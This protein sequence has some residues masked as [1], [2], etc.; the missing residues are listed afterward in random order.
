MGQIHST[1][2]EEKAHKCPEEVMDLKDGS[3][4]QRTD[5]PRGGAGGKLEIGSQHCSLHYALGS[6]GI[7]SSR[8]GTQHPKGS[9]GFR[10]SQD[11]ELQSTGKGSAQMGSRQAQ[12]Q[13]LQC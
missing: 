7:C 5:A 6:A 3:D 2:I 11:K 9:R 4:T 13:R 8:P 12:N 1:K 10:G